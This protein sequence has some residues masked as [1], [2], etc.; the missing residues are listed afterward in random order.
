MTGRLVLLVYWLVC[1]FGAA[2]LLLWQLALIPF[3]PERSL[4]VARAID[5]AGAT[6]LSG[7]TGKTL[8]YK[9]ARHAEEGA[10]WAKWLCQALNVISPNHC[11][12]S[13]EGGDLTLSS[14]Q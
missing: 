12:S 5:V 14:I 11:K 8:S 7:D 10:W 2:L 1:L 4:K 13:L 3:T 6:A 9:C